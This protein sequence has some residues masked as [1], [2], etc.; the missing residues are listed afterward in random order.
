MP[1]MMVNLLVKLEI[2]QY[3]PS[4]TRKVQANLIDDNFEDYLRLFDFRFSSQ[5]SFNE[6]LDIL[7]NFEEKILS[8][9]NIDDQISKKLSLYN[10]QFLKVIKKYKK[11]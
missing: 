11:L 4:D 2:F 3:S 8:K 6:G 9:Y 1:M 5:T 10:K 7:H